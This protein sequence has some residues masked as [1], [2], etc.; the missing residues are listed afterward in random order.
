[1]AKDHHLDVAVQ[2]IGAS[3]KLDKASSSRY[4]S[5][6]NTDG[7]SQ[8][9]E[10][11]CYELAAEAMIAGFC[12]LQAP[13]HESPYAGL[14][15]HNCGLRILKASWWV[16]VCPGTGTDGSPPGRCTLSTAPALTRYYML[17]DR[18]GHWL[19]WFLYP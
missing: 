17:I 6:K 12:A 5:A 16:A 15:R 8:E 11:R 14:I 19:V 9:K 7:T 13:A 18:R 1:M 4:A 2:L 3:E 10:A